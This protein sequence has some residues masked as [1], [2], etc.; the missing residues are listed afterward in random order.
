MA[1]VAADHWARIGAVAAPLF[2]PALEERKL[3]KARG[4]AEAVIVDLEDA[5]SDERKDEARDWAGAITGPYQG[6]WIRVNGVSTGRCLADVEGVARVAEVIILPKCESENDIRLV[7]RELERLGSASVVI[8]ILE[9]AAGVEAAGRIARAAPDRVPRLSLG[10]GDLSRDLGI[11]WEPAGPMAQHARCHLGITSRAAGL[12]AP[13]DTV[14]PT[15]GNAQMLLADVARAR[16]AGFSG[17]FCI[18]PNQVGEVRAGFAP[19]DAEI[20]MARRQMEAF[21]DAIA[22]GKAAVVVDGTFIDYPVAEIAEALLMRAGCPSGLLARP[23]IAA[24][25]AVWKSHSGE[26]RDSKQETAHRRVVAA[27]R[28]ADHGPRIVVEPARHRRQGGVHPPCCRCRRAGDRD[29]RLCASE[30]DSAA[31]RR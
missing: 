4:L 12:A 16:A 28:V 8:P 18:H 14:Y 27:R 7:D 5:V 13:L 6:L 29:H 19:S 26:C 1:V 3:A 24:L 2:V 10:L 11:A 22:A 31:G 23:R 30:G 17:K 15:L 20:A 9:T 25:A 21:A